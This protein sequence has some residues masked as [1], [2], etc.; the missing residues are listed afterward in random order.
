MSWRTALSW[1]LLVV[2]SDEHEDACYCLWS[3]LRLRRAQSVLK[4]AVDG[5]SAYQVWER[6][7][8][9]EAPGEEF[10]DLQKRLAE[11]DRERASILIAL[12]QLERGL[13]A[14]M[15]P[16]PRSETAGDVATPT[17]MSNAEKVAL[18]RSLFRGRD[19]IFP[20]AGGKIQT[21]VRSATRLRAATNGF[22]ASARSR[23]SSAAT[24]R[25]RHSCLLVTKS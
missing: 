15:Q 12:E 13:K 25:T 19:D 20:P 21:P 7:A 2:D 10:A 14:P 23:G 6:M 1:I 11:L 8:A 22:A 9:D 3:E 4:P 17:V 18:F 5:I 24:A 16:A